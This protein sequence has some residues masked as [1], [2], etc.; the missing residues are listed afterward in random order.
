[1]SDLKLKP[2]PAL[3][4]AKAAAAERTSLEI[5]DGWTIALIAERKGQREAL[6]QRLHELLGITL[7]ESGRV[8]TSG[9]ITAVWAGPG[10][11]L[12]IA[13]GNSCRDLE[14][15]LRAPLEGLAAVTDQSDSRAVVKVSGPNARDVLAKGVPVDL[16]A[17]AF[18]PGD[19]AITHAAHIGITLWRPAA[20]DTFVITCSSSYAD[21]F[22]HWLTDACQ[23]SGLVVS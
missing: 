16:H 2:R 18:K 21:S 8:T 23:S 14:R 7:S 19:A 5:I 4:G 1:M 22:W 12:L 9:S 13:D 11:W 10:Q 3:Y 6:A 15:D 17:R 20:D